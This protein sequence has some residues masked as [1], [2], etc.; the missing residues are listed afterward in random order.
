MTSSLLSVVLPCRNQADHIGEV[1]A[2]YVTCFDAA[3]LNYE[4]IVVPNASTD[5]TADAVRALGKVNPR[6]RVVES[7]LGGWGRAVL[8]G[9]KEARGD[10]LCYTNSARTEPAHVVELLALYE[11]HAP[12]L[13]KVRR[14]KRNAPLRELGSLL[15]NLEGWLLFGVQT[16]DVNGTPKI[17]SRAFYDQV[18]LESLGD[19]IDMELMARAKQCGIP[20]V[21]LPVAGFKRHGGKS[22]TNYTS[23]WNMYVGAWQLRRQMKPVSTAERKAA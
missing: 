3:G 19:C 10:T 9:L 11:A 1:L 16:G 20:L 7:A 18:P 6:L 14:E 15:Y 23:A 21:E 17:F 2:R 4:L 5:G 13:A 12:C 8:C 22:S